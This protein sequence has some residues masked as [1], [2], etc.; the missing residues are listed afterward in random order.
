MFKQ[1]P[2]L[3]K[4]KPLSIINFC[5]FLGFIVDIMSLIKFPS[6][7]ALTSV[8]KYIQYLYSHGS[9]FLQFLMM[10]Y[11]IHYKMKEARVCLHQVGI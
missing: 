4:T 6:A 5:G 11:C 10:V 2:Y 7:L 3:L 8:H 9:R 1:F